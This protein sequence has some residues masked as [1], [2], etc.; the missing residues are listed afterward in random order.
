[1][2]NTL[3]LA[4]SIIIAG[5]FIGGGLYL[6]KLP[7]NKKIIS[8]QDTTL[9]KGQPIVVKGIQADDYVL[10]P[11]DAKVVIIE[12]SDPECPFC[13]MFHN[14]M[15]TLMADKSL[16]GKIA[17]VY[18]HFP[19]DG[20]HK[21]AR[22]EAQAL[23]CAGVVGGNEG[24]WNMTN[25][26]YEVATSNDTLDLSI[27][28]SLAEGIG[29]SREDFSACLA[30]GKMAA[31]VE[32]DYQSGIAAGATATPYFI[33]IGPNGQKIPTTGAVPLASIKVQVQSLLG[34]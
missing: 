10:G 22:Y 9:S 19:L 31:K 6:S 13:K 28:P 3:V 7:T 18:R 24:F 30:D 25:K 8:P 32:S 16:S 4:G 34:L 5:V 27:L 21:K 29:L 15:I 26:L 20:I 12:Y 17:W 33:I 23:E 1:M 2:K 11:K 14:T